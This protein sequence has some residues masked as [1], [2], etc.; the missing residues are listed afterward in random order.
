MPACA[1]AVDE[2]GLLGIGIGPDGLVEADLPMDVP[3][4]ALVG[5][6]LRF[7]CLITFCVIWSI[8]SCG[9]PGLADETDSPIRA[10]R[11]GLYRPSFSGALEGSG[12]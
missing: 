11:S 2:Y 8:T 5:V 9:T 3:L 1:F 10:L 12:G 7:N 4:E 6:E